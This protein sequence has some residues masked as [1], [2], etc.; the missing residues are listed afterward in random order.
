MSEAAWALF[1]HVPPGWATEVQAIVDYVH[2]HITF[3]YERTPSRPRAPL[4]SMS[5]GGACAATTPIWRSPSADAWAFRARYCTGYLGDIGVPIVGEMDFSAWFRG[6]SG[7][8][9]W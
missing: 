6:L 4:T 5:S 3:G 8:P 9:N 7:R 1:G 2:A